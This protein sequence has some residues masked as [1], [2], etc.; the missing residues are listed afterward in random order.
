MS[1]R[2]T[3]RELVLE[4]LFR[5]HAR[6]TD[7]DANSHQHRLQLVVDDTTQ[8]VLN[9]FLR[10][11]DLIEEGVTS[12]ELVTRHRQPIPDLDV[13]YMMHPTLANIQY[14]LADFKT[15]D[16]PQHKHVHFAFT[17]H[18]A[19]QVMESLTS[20]PV[21]PARVQ[22]LVEVPLNFITV[23]DRGFHFGMADA[24]TFQRVVDSFSLNEITLRLTDVFQCLH[25]MDPVIRHCPSKMCK[26]VADG[27]QQELSSLRSR[28]IHQQ[29]KDDIPCK[30]LIVDRSIDIAATLVHHYTYEALAYDL[31]DGTGILDVDRNVVNI[32]KADKDRASNKSNGHEVLLCDKDV[33][34]EQ[35]KHSHIQLVREEVQ[36]RV[37]E[38]SKNNQSRDVSQVSEG[39][40]L[41][42]L[43]RSPE[44]KDTVEK[45]MLHMSLLQAID[46]RIKEQHLI[47]DSSGMDVGGVEQDVACGVNE[48]GKEIKPP[49]MQ[50]TLSR[51][52]SRADMCLSSEAKLRLL[53]LYFGCVAQTPAALTEKLVESAKLQP[54]DHDVLMSWMRSRLT[55]VSEANSQNWGRA[56]VHRSTKEQTLR[57]KHNEKHGR[58]KLSRFEPYVK[59]LLEELSANTLSKEQFPLFNEDAAVSEEGANPTGDAGR[60]ARAR[61]V[62]PR[63]PLPSQQQTTFDDWSFAP[64]ATTSRGM[65]SD[66]LQSKQI[67]QRIVIFIVG[68]IT[69]S[70]LR[71][72]SEMTANLPRGTEVIIGGTSLITP[73]RL[74]EA[75]RQ[76]SLPV[77][78]HVADSLDLT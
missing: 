76:T 67:S 16:K 35:L 56:C 22:S 53:M 58:F 57:F 55:E 75:L 26:L 13:M 60:R 42:M 48:D 15:H 1:L 19:S 70:E 43:R 12:I 10:V 28:S 61:S 66:G 37:G 72:A 45:L 41:D 62:S 44:H 50:D 40:L 7:S 39:E 18:V 38:L 78:S 77:E 63:A 6:T 52:F 51:L 25:T 64:A 32:E 33:V 27:L 9:S 49:N 65:N 11:T 20:S 34:W 46:S 74:I 4:V 71:V 47:E 31:L 54:E 59:V 2:S 21:L 30:L 14:V 29:N 68:G 69:H 3:C 23:Q 24:L 5:Q 73:R 36:A 17:Q 8:R